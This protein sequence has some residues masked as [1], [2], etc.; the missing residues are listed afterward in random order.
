MRLVPSELQPRLAKKPETNRNRGFERSISGLA[1][2]YS[3]ST[4]RSLHDC[5]LQRRGPCD[6]KKNIQV[7][8]LS[9]N[10]HVK[11]NRIKGRRGEEMIT[12][13]W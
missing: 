13:S 5:C 7:F 12:F 10:E 2:F 3:L 1:L 9:N 8:K 6:K 11:G 4:I